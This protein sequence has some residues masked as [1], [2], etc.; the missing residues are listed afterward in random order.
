MRGISP[1]QTAAPCYTPGTDLSRPH[2]RQHFEGMMDDYF[3]DAN[4]EINRANLT[5]P[6][7]IGDIN[8]LIDRLM[9]EARSDRMARVVV[10]SDVSP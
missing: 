9:A 7:G 10:M 8:P 3:D 2:D 6:M 5:V 4:Q 1:C